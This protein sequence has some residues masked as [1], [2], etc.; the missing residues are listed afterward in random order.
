MRAYKSEHGQTIVLI[1]LAL[2]VLFGFAAL[3]VD[4]G[5]LYAEQRRAQN[6]ADAAAYAAASAGIDST[7]PLDLS[8]RAAGLAQAGLNDFVDADA[9]PNPGTLLDVEIYH[10]PVDGDHAGDLGYY[11]AKIRNHVDQVFSQIVYHDGLEVSVDAVAR[12]KD[13]APAADGDWPR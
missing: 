1:G 13:E 2:V 9:G 3:A 8:W 12:G 6:A 5:R 10:P 4:G 7:G 11:Q